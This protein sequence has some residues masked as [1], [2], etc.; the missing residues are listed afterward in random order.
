MWGANNYVQQPTMVG[1]GATRIQSQQPVPQ[2]GMP[3]AMPLNYPQY[4]QQ[5][6]MYGSRPK[7]T[8]QLFREK[9]Q[10]ATNN[11]FGPKQTK[12]EKLQMIKQNQV[13]MR[14]L[15]TKL[16]NTGGYINKI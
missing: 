11:A 10:Y 9:A 15:K 13:N 4:N 3:G 14:G 1:M 16:K 12:Q 5:N 7:T 2:V 6:Q 8:K